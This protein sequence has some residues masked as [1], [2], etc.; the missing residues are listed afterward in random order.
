MN[1]FDGKYDDDD[2]IRMLKELTKSAC[3]KSFGNQNSIF[4]SFQTKAIFITKSKIKL[5]LLPSSPK[6]TNKILNLQYFY[7]HILI[8]NKTTYHRKEEG[9]LIKNKQS[10]KKK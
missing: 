4:A 5:H 7:L 6:F 1:K 10:K 9:K 8:K 3:G 2:D